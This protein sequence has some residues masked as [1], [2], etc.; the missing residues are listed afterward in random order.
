MLFFSTILGAKVIDSA[1]EVVGKVTDALVKMTPEKKYPTVLGV[2]IKSSLHKKKD[3][4]L[5]MDMIENWGPGE[6]ELEG[7]LNGD[8]EEIPSGNHVFSLRKNVLDKQIVDL[9]GMRIVRVN[10]LQL[11]RVQRTMSLIAIDVS[12]RGILR[13]LG[14]FSQSL[15]KIFRPHLI[16]WNNISPLDNK[17]HLHTGA[18]DLLKLHPADIAN[19][20]E[21][22]NLKQSGAILETMDKATAARVLEEV[23]PSIKKILVKSLGAGR[24][25]DL[26]GKM[27]VDELVD[28]MQLLP[29]YE[30]R[31]ILKK[32][33]GSPKKENVKK[34]MEYD[35]D[36]AGGLMTTE[37]IVVNPT[38]T[39]GKVI[40]KI[41]ETLHH[42]RHTSL[43]VY[44]T[45]KEGKFKGVVPLK[46]LLTS[47][48]KQKIQE[49][50]GKKRKIHTVKVDQS[51]L[52][53]ATLMTK[54]NLLSVAVL[55]SKKKL[56]GIIT[57]DDVMREFIPNA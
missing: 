39:V 4:F 13:R 40:E 20:I 30:S 55:D 36:T 52:S 23:Q 9:A 12:T 43:F 22:M 31:E 26:M 35:E 56:L 47:T 14:F 19:I 7:K 54:Y 5:P 16:E 38:A 1:E 42:P 25:A 34:F 51:I 28:I 27:S 37:F 18:Q 15:S 57:V 11:G 49:I 33:P 32:L 8:I 24:A 44:V 48:K 50:M 10:D 17:I 3:L 41:K 6:I 29:K 46:K 45:D 21:R 2:V 53:V